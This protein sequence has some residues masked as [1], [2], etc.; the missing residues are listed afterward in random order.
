MEYAILNEDG[1]YKTKVTTTGKL[2]WDENTF[3]SA[4]AL[5]TD[6]KA[7]QFNVVEFYETEPPIIDPM[8]EEVLFDGGEYVDG[9]W[10]YK[11]KIQPYTEE[12]IAYL[13]AEEKRKQIAKLIDAVDFSLNAFART[14][15]YDSISSACTYVTS[16][17]QKY[18]EEAAY[19]VELKSETWVKLYEIIAEINSG[20]RAVPSSISE[21]VNELPTP[22]WPN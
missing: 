2:H 11:W 13:A 9:R 1:T 16:S 15:N 21:I 6:G 20:V 8:V 3:C 12:R 7:E 10:Q 19:C 5:F 17:V 14:R 4:E 18:A 22:T